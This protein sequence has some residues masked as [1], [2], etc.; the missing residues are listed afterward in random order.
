MVS[1][2]FPVA[3][4]TVI[5]VFKSLLLCFRKAKVQKREFSEEQLR[6]GRRLIGMQ[7]G[8]NRGASQSGMVGYGTPR[9]IMRHDSPRH[10]GNES[11]SNP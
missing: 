4:Y 6:Q 8:S 9:Q 10:N 3:V 5:F 7:M 2:I 11:D 1:Y